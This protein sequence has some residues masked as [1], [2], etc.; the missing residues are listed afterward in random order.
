MAGVGLRPSE[1]Q[2]GLNRLFWGLA[3]VDKKTPAARAGVWLVGRYSN[4]VN[5]TLGRLLR[6]AQYRLIH[7]IALRRFFDASS[8]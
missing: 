7:K 8:L 6:V 5:Q 3:V 2:S 1:R 4:K